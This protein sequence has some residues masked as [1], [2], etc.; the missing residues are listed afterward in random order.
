MTDHLR[1][2]ARRDDSLIPLLTLLV[3]VAAFGPAAYTAVTHWLVP[4]LSAG[5][6][7][8]TLSLAEW[9]DR[10]WWLVVFWVLEL[11]VLF[12]VLGWSRRRRRR[13]DRQMDSVVTGLSRSLPADWQP[14]RDLRV[15]RWS[16][17]RP[18]RL[19]LQLTPRSALDDPTWRQSLADAAG[20]VLGPIEP[21]AWPRPPR[22]GVFDWGARPPR[23]ELRVTS[24]PSAETPPAANRT[25]VRLAESSDR[26]AP[27]SVRSRAEEFPIYRRPR[28]ET[29]E[30]VPVEQGSAPTRVD[31]E[32]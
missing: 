20:K 6:D 21:I 18:V 26:I 31:R 19:R 2:R 28:P 12:T 8:V 22:S 24:R 32:D 17:H 23:I 4:R 11:A 30:R 9:W 10:N 3:V 7:A 15:L 29:S 1:G 25:E 27:L 13:R 16:G 14:G 5:G